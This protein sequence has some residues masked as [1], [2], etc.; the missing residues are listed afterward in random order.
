MTETGPVLV[1]INARM[2]GSVSPV[3]YQMLTGQDAYEHLVRLHLGEP[4]EVNDAGFAAAG[5]T[6]AVAARHGG[7]IAAT[8]EQGQLQALL[9]QYGITFNT[10]AIEAGKQIDKYEAISA[11]WGT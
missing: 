5:I 1:E 3:M 4:V 11:S 8:F 9:D 6:L 2:M 10:L 7:R